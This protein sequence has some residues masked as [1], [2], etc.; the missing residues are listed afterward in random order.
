MTSSIDYVSDLFAVN[1]HNFS[2]YNNKTYRIDDVDWEKNPT[3][4]FKKGEEEMDLVTYYQNVSSPIGE[5]CR[6]NW[7]NKLKITRMFK[8]IVTYP[9][10]LY[11]YLLMFV[12]HEMSNL[13]PTVYRFN[14]NQFSTYL[15][16]QQYNIKITDMQQPLLVSMPKARD[17]KRGQT[18]PILLVP[19]LCRLTGE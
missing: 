10:Y 3:Y 1:L 7:R 6:G 13:S 15:I 17:V 14:D 11:M 19:E 12:V 5:L 2:R 4:K 18:D 16:S 9:I 8:T